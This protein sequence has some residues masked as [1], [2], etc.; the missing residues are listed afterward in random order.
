MKKS[1]IKYYLSQILNDE[2]DF[3]NCGLENQ[4]YYLPNVFKD[5]LK[6]L[7]VKVDE[8]IIEEV[9]DGKFELKIKLEGQP[10]ERF[11]Q[12]KAW[13]EV[14]EVAE[15]LYEMLRTNI[16]PNH[17]VSKHYIEIRSYSNSSNPYHNE[18]GYHIKINREES[19]YQ[20]VKINEDSFL[21]FIKN[22]LAKEIGGKGN[23][24]GGFIRWSDA[25]NIEK[26]SD[27]EYIVYVNYPI[28]D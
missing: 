14:D 8:M 26:L 17:R 21:D 13:N 16:V 6:E 19:E 2:K 28:G 20:H 5:L 22:L 18:S 24:S 12:F 4:D 27:N 3:M 10:K 7:D 15:D 25:A 1:D 9:S 11:L 23:G